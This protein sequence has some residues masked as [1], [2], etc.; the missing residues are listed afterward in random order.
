MR[1]V[2]IP[3]RGGLGSRHH[4]RTL[5]TSQAWHLVRILVPYQVRVESDVDGVRTLGNFIAVHQR[6]AAHSSPVHGEIGAA[7]VLSDE[8]GTFLVIEE[9]YD[10]AN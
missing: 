7:V 3:L 8:A 4:K 9:F 6:L 10:A 2:K 1:H 5:M